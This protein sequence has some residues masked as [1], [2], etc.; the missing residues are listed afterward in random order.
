[1]I[2]LNQ[3]ENNL[4][5]DLLPPGEGERFVYLLEIRVDWLSRLAPPVVGHFVNGVC[6]FFGAEEVVRM[7]MEKEGLSVMEYH[8]YVYCK[9]LDSD[10]DPV[11]MTERNLK[12]FFTAAQV[13]GLPSDPGEFVSSH[14]LIPYSVGVLYPGQQFSLTTGND[15][16]EDFFFYRADG[17]FDRVNIPLA[18]DTLTAYSAEWSDEYVRMEAYIEQTRRFTLYFLSGSAIEHFRFRNVFNC[19][20]SVSFPS[21]LTQEPSEEFDTEYQDTDL[22]K[23]DAVQLLDLSV[24]SG[25]LP[26]FLYDPLLALC[27]ANKAQYRVGSEWCDIIINKYK[28]DKSDEPNQPLRLDM[29][30]EFADTKRLGGGDY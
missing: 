30:F 9:W 20:E 4:P 24:K 12:I 26:V 7:H 11:Y 14:Y 23:F 29:D 28:F 22:K 5:A 10:A 1:M 3:I 19:W 2:L 8:F 17:S 25:L 27:R 13:I 16:D 18:P 15:R 21:A 6:R